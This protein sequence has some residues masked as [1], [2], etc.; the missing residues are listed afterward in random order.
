MSPPN[1][2][3][4]AARRDETFSLTYQSKRRG[5]VVV[6]DPYIGLEVPL[7][8]SRETKVCENVYSPALWM[9]T[10]LGLCLHTS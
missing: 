2:G 1:W 4:P 9:P 10:F 7:N 6:P 8:E 3:Y 5:S